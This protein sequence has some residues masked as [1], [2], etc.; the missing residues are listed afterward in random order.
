MIQNYLLNSR[1]CERY[2]QSTA[3]PHLDHF[4][5]WLSAQGYRHQTIRRLIRGA[6]L[7]SQWA[8]S[9]ELS[10]V[11]MGS[12]ALSDFEKYLADKDQL[13]SSSG[14]YRGGFLGARKFMHYLH[15][16]ELSNAPIAELTPDYPE[17]YCQFT[18]WMRTHRD[19]A[20][21]TLDGYRAIL[22]DMLERLGEYPEVYTANG[23]REFVLYRVQQHN[24]RS[25]Q[26]VISAMRMF[27]RY[28][29]ITERVDSTLEQSI[30][31]VAAWQLQSLPRCLPANIIDAVINR[32]DSNTLLGARNRSI[33]LLLAHLGLRAGEVAGLS[34]DDIDWRNAT[35]R[36]RDKCRR[37]SRLPMPQIVGDALLHYLENY[38]PHVAIEQIF[39]STLAPYRALRRVSVS[40]ISTQALKQAGAAYPRLGAH[41]FRHSIASTLLNEGLSLQTIATVLRHSSLESTRIYTKVDQA[42]LQQVTLPWPEGE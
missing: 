16:K 42:L 5:V 33:F 24:K 27:L 12:K 38:R 20:E 2:Y 13:K 3:G 31:N 23:M 29:V 22:L 7:F 25:A 14:S 4:V 8:D 34:I 11:D 40:Q 9:H 21:S 18:A 17:L 39:L 41:M 28:L 36:I 10:V 30:P 19:V 1:A 35:L 26:N 37:E 32:C 15:D 6:V